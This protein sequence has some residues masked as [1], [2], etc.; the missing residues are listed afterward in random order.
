PDV[1]TQLQF[2][3][4]NPDGTKQT[5]TNA[6]GEE[7]G[8][9]KLVTVR[10]ERKVLTFDETGT[11]RD[12]TV[13]ARLK[14]LADSNQTYANDI[15]LFVDFDKGISGGFTGQT[16]S[17]GGRMIISRDGGNTWEELVTNVSEP[18]AVS[19]PDFGQNQNLP[20]EL[21]D[22]TL[23]GYRLFIGSGSAEVIED[24][25][26]EFNKD[27]SVYVEEIE[28]T[29]ALI[30]ETPFLDELAA[31]NL[32]YDDDDTF[33]EVVHKAVPIVTNRTGLEFDLSLL[34]RGLEAGASFAAGVDIGPFDIGVDLGFEFGPLLDEE[35]LLFSADLIDFFND[36]F[37]IEDS[38]TTSFVLGQAAGPSEYGDAIVLTDGNDTYTSTLTG[39]DANEQIIALGGEDSI[40]AG[41]GNDTINLGVGTDSI[42]G[43]DGFDTL[44]LSDLGGSIQSSAT[45]WAFGSSN[46]IEARSANTRTGLT[47]NA[48]YTFKTEFREIDVISYDT[49]TGTSGRHIGED[50]ER[51]ILSDLSDDL[52]LWNDGMPREWDTGSGNDRVHILRSI[53]NSISVDTGDGNDLVIDYGENTSGSTID[54][55]DGHDYLLTDNSF[56]L[57]DGSAPTGTVFQN[58]ESVAART[59]VGFSQTFRGNDGANTLDGQA[60]EDTLEGRGGNDLL[61]GGADNDT[62]IGGAGADSMV[63]GTGTDAAS[64]ADSA[65]SVFIDLDFGG[66]A[67]GFRGEAQGDTFSSV[68]HIIGSAFE[69]I[70]I[71]DNSGNTLDGGGGDDRLQSQ[72]GDD[73]LIGGSGNDLLNR[74]TTATLNGSFAN[75][76]EGGEGFDLVA[77]DVFNPFTQTGS[78]TGEATFTYRV[79]TTGFPTYQTTLIDDTEDVTI[80]HSYLRSAHVELALDETG[81]G[82]LLFVEDD[83]TDRFLTTSISGTAKYSSRSS[84]ADF[85]WDVRSTSYSNNTPNQSPEDLD[86]DSISFTKGDYH[87]TS[88][89]GKITDAAGRPSG[90]AGGVFGTEQVTGVEGAIGSQGNDRLFGNSQDNAF[91]GN[92]GDDMILGGLGDDRLGFGEAQALSD[93]FSFPGSSSSSV[94]CPPGQVCDN[95]IFYTLED[96]LQGM[97]PYGTEINEGNFSRLDE[98][99]PVGRIQISASSYDDIGS[100]LWGQGGEDWLDMRFDRGLE[101]F[102]DTSDSYVVVDLNI[103]NAGSLVNDFTGEVLEYGRATYFNA[104]GTAQNYGTT[105]GVHNVYGTR[106]NDTITGD[107]Q[108]NTI[109]GGDGADSMDGDAGIDALSY[110]TAAEGVTLNF[111]EDAGSMILDNGR[112]TVTGAG[113][114]TGD[115]GRNFEL[116]IGSDFDD[117]AILAGSADSVTAEFPVTFDYF[118]YQGIAPVTITTTET[119]TF[120]SLN[121]D[122]LGVGM[123]LDMGAGDDAVILEGFG[124][125]EVGLGNGEDTAVLKNIGNTIDGGAGND[126]ITVLA[127]DQISLQDVAAEDRTTTIDG[128]ADEDTVIFTGGD[129]VS[130]ELTDTGAVVTERVVP[131]FSATEFFFL[132]PQFGPQS[133]L[134]T[135]E[136]E[137]IAARNAANA[138]VSYDLTNVEFVEIDG[139]RI[140]IDNPDP[141]VDADKTISLIEDQVD[142]YDLGLSLT[143]EDPRDPTVTSPFEITELPITAGI[144][145]ALGVPVSVGD[146]FTA[147]EM[148]ALRVVPG[149]DFDPNTDGLSFRRVG[150]APEDTLT[151]TLPETVRGVALNITSH[152]TEETIEVTPPV[153]P[154]PTVAMV[155]LNPGLLASDLPTPT[156]FD[157]AL[158]PSV[159]DMPTGDFTFEMLFRSFGELDPAGPDQVFASYSAGGNNN[160]FLIY[161]YKD[162]RGL[163]V[164]FNGRRLETGIR[165]DEL[166]DREMH[167]LSVR[168]DPT[169]DVIEVLIDGVLMYSQVSAISGGLAAGGTLV[170]GQEQDAPG[171]G[172]SSTQTLSGQV[173]DVRIWDSFRTDA[174]IQALAFEEIADP[175]GEADLAANWRA[176]TTNQGVMVNAVGSD[177]LQLFNGPDVTDLELPEPANVT[178]I[179]TVRVNVQPAEDEAIQVGS[180][181]MP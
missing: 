101:F 82:D 39:T 171:G 165:L 70:I 35:F 4:A 21:N 50:L 30:S 22:D 53:I 76:Y 114:A 40:D 8:V 59:N 18:I 159:T 67:R 32:V 62:L 80:N 65:T 75:V 37:Q 72:D 24:Y 38:R 162:G 83:A 173:G 96:R 180:F 147:E 51:V 1:V 92:G 7:V 116:T 181:A 178:V 9:E 63:G 127:H 52:Y 169:N 115:V 164:S 113:D 84:I 112:E 25:V 139:Q 29:E 11:F 111:R 167:R 176:D 74:G 23:L 103:A 45:T 118:T 132:N 34:L 81:S 141:V 151:V 166:F 15:D 48:G 155:G 98:V 14:Q 88:G 134:L 149:Q 174:E 175:A 87:A 68:E 172:F 126:Q 85:T 28:A 135:D 3:E 46:P 73:L 140:R 44:D 66:V 158:T 156:L 58:F 131:P 177:H 43:G 20:L 56:D 97:N 146:V 49:V 153:A 107:G 95:R 138:V 133:E 17:V 42:D 13:E 161:S 94:P 121:A 10:T 91:F 102:P 106:N 86:D 79:N 78:R 12:A 125:H 170:I 110:A 129:Y 6:E 108:A 123:A 130:L 90:I 136:P 2:F 27:D 179:P 104:A 119:I 137:Y 152:L 93:V 109:I 89:S 71:G 69:D 47:V 143:A 36:S 124:A 16:A 77:A 150:D 117:T 61:I 120:E 19:E 57:E 55:G 5:T 60:G 148:N 41:I 157:Y 33:V 163:E 105:F 54:G 128:G 168:I 100:F 26:I 160:E 31:L 144:T 142:P 64:Y 145:T 99:T 154:A 122:S